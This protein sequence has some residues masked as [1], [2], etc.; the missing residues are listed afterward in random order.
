MTIIAMYLSLL[1]PAKTL[2]Y[3]LP[4]QYSSYSHLLFVLEVVEDLILH[5]HTHTHTTHTCDG[6]T[7]IHTHRSVI[8]QVLNYSDS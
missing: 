8:L 2:V 3:Q 1:H 5:T 4:F 6:H 7:H